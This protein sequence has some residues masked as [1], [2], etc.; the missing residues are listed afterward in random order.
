VLHAI[1]SEEFNAAIIH[2]NRDVNRDFARGLAEN[3]PKTW[4]KVEL[5]RGQFEARCLRLPR[6]GFHVRIDCG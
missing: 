3:L 2:L 5:S 1:S 4:V 6:I